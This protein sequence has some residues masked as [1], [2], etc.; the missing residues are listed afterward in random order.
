[1]DIKTQSRYPRTAKGIITDTYFETVVADP[2]RWLED[3]TSAATKNWV[4]DRGKQ[5]NERLN[6]TGVAMV[7]LTSI[8]IMLNRF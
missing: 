5:S 7:H 2:Y 4:Q 1:M 8:R 6:N 3:D